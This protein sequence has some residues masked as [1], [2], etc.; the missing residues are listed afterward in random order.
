VWQ[1]RSRV[2]YRHMHMRYTSRVFDS[3]MTSR[4]TLTAAGLDRISF[5]KRARIVDLS[6]GAR[7]GVVAGQC[8]P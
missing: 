1:A 2:R 7:V 4:R 8:R 3:A 5:R 6:G